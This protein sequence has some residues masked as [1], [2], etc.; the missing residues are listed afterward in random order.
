MLSFFKLLFVLCFVFIVA[1][2]TVEQVER[3]DTRPGLEKKPTVSRLSGS[4]GHDGDLSHPSFV[5]R[6]KDNTAG[7]GPQTRIIGGTDAP[8]GRYPYFVSLLTAFRGRT[9]GGTLVAPDVV[10]TAA[11]CR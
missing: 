11:H 1:A 9:C 4:M 2:T 8:R 5:V 10:L 6:Q 7:Q 3:T